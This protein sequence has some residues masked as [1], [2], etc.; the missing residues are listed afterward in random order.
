MRVEKVTLSEK[1]LQK[2]FGIGNGD[3]ALLYIYLRSGN[4]I[5]TA[6]ELGLNPNQLSLAEA[7]LRQMGLWEEEKKASFV[8][9]ERPAYSENDVI[10]AMDSDGDFRSL[11]GEIQRLL[12]KNLN[13]EELKLLLGFSRYLGLSN[14]VISVLVCYCKEAA[15][16]RGSL[17]APSLRTIEK[18][19]YAW[20]EQGI[21]TLEQAAAYIR[22]RNLR[23]S[24]MEKLKQQL[25]IRGRNLTAGE[26]KYA[27][28]WLDMGFAD[29]VVAMAYERTCLNTGG[30]SWA[31]MNKILQR[32]HESGL[33]TAEEVRRGDKKPA[34]PKGA[35]GQLGQAELEAIERLMREGNE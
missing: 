35:S 14:D 23:N 29:E 2:L 13:T 25:Q 16:N 7:M 8:P 5:H 18:E 20:A 24:R 19:A 30:L 11:Y 26:E 34:V 22:S 3:A 31:Y 33:H 10:S 1:E 4:S 32:W 6:A 28:S 21:E 17:R 12:G 15:R 9:G 27:Q